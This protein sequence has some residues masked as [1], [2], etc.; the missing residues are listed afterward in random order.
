MMPLS[1][2]I[3]LGAMLRRQC[4]GALRGRDGTCA[5][6]AALDALGYPDCGF[7]ITL[8]ALVPWRAQCPVCA[9]TAPVLACVLCLNDQHHWTREAIAEWVS[10]VE[11]AHGGWSEASCGVGAQLHGQHPQGAPGVTGS[12]PVS[13]HQFQAV[14]T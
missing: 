3:R 10:T 4:F 14:T 1:T 2:A 11:Q 13:R 8:D 7:E 5:L 12:E 6:G 9:C